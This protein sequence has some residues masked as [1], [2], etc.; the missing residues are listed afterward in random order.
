MVCGDGV[1]WEGGVGSRS[2]QNVQRGVM[3]EV[4]MRSFAPQ[5]RMYMRRCGASMRK[6]CVRI[7]GLNQECTCAGM[8]PQYGMHMCGDGASIEK[9]EREGEEMAPV[10]LIIELR[11]AAAR[12]AALRFC[13]GFE[14]P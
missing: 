10:R 3:K 5:Y 13:N 8:G 1:V 2:I 9:K 4:Y 12:A 14:V 7:S 11:C 6:V